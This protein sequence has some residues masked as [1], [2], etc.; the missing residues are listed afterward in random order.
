M[1]SKF[2]EFSIEGQGWKY[3]RDTNGKLIGIEVKIPEIDKS[4]IKKLN[5][6]L[7]DNPGVATFKRKKK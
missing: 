2:R 4:V 6:C 3:L 5:K 7:R 1:K